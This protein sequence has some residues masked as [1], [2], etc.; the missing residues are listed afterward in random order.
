MFSV[1]IYSYFL[2]HFLRNHG[3]RAAAG[4][5]TRGQCS[6]DFFTRVCDQLYIFLL[7]HLHLT[8]GYVTGHPVWHISADGFKQ[9]L[10]L[11]SSTHLLWRAFAA[12][13][14]QEGLPEFAPTV[15]Q[16][17]HLWAIQL[18]IFD[19]PLQPRVDN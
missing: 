7:A 16:E 2:A 5:R 11:D 12:A 13:M 9:R 19:S 3:T 15:R 4:E 1:N 17:V 14:A 10:A 8:R 6:T 18:G